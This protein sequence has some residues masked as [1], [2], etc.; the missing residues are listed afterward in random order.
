MTART[1]PPFR[2]DHVGSL[3]RPPELLRARED[4]A[5][6]RIDAAELRGVEDDAIRDVVRG[7][8]DVGLRSATDGEFR[9]ASWHMDF[10]YRLGGVTRA[11]DTMKVRFRNAEGSLEFTPAALRVDAPVALEEPIFADDFGF[12]QSCVS[13][14]TPK[15]TIPRRAW[16]TTAAAAPRSTKASTPTSTASGPTSRAPTATRSAR[17]PGSAARTCRSTTRASPTSTTPSSGR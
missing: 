15:L 10:I 4:F 1:R 16:S 14:A 13:T 3:L 2:A 6:D 8:E 9:R 5:A 11:S 17:W 12:L 7:Q